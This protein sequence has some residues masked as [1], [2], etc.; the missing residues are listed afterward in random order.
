MDWTNVLSVFAQQFLLALAP[1]VASLL[2]AWVFAK[3]RLAWAE[4]KADHGDYAYWLELV[5]GMAVK[6]AEQA[7][8]SDLIVDK[9]EYAF[10]IIERWL[11]Q[12]G[13]TLDVDI[14]YAAIEAAVLE[15][16]NR[17]KLAVGE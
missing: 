16:F 9:R 13:V 1:I 17:H 15:E 2:A 10:E 4:L 12:K 14:I 5:A 3:A 8:M 7:K 11:S 6:A